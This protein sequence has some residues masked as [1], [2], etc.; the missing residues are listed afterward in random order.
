MLKSWMLV[1]DLDEYFSG[2]ARTGEGDAMDV[3]S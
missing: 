3:L 2:K 1:A